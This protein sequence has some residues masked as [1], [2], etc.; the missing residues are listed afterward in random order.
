MKGGRET[1][2]YSWA[3]LILTLIG[4]D[5]AT[6]AIVAERIVDPFR[7]YVTVIDGFLGFT[8]SRNK[9]I[10]F[11]L[12]QG[13][14]WLFIPTTVITVAL[15]AYVFLKSRGSIIRLPLALILAG[16][17]G[18]LTDRVVQADGVIDFIDVPPLSFIF[19]TFN[20]ADALVTMGGVMAA[21]MMLFSARL[22]RLPP[23]G[24][25]PSFGRADAEPS[26]GAGEA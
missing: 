12:L 8:I 16:A 22:R 1:A 4:V 5:Q 24:A 11:G 25:E 13:M 21:A 2:M 10:A 6:K 9:G 7:D 26:D 19:P 14:W 23:F 3:M 18:N 15:L 20:V 17:F